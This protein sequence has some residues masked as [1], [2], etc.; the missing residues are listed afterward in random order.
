MI[1]LA[2]L[3]STW[4]KME[5]IGKMFAELDQEIGTDIHVERTHESIKFQDFANARE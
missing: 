4:D 2:K 1:R 5:Q 3:L